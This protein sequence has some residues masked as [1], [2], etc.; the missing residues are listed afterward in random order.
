VILHGE[1]VFPLG[2]LSVFLV[3]YGDCIEWGEVLERVVIIYCATKGIYYIKLKFNK[4]VTIHG[5]RY[6]Q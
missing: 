1:K 5:D 3:G 2:S 4:P 6:H